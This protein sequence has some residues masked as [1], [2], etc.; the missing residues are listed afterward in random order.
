[1]SKSNNWNYFF[2][3]VLNMKYAINKTDKRVAVKD[4]DGTVFYSPEEIE[5][6]AGG[7]ITLQLHMLKKV[8]NGE[9]VNID[10]EVAD[11]N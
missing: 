2:S 6:L 8:F 10:K 1:M 11:V 3:K 5:V 7:Q 9:I 4:P